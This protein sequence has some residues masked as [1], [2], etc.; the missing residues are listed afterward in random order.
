MKPLYLLPLLLLASC[1]KDDEI[2]APAPDDTPD[3]PTVIVYDYTPAPG[4]FIGEQPMAGFTGGE[5]TPAAAIA[6][7]EGRLEKGLFVS[8][9]G[10]G[11][12]IVMGLG[13]PIANSHGGYDFA[14]RGNAFLSDNGGG[15][16][17]P[18]IV[19]VMR[20]DNGNGLPDD[21]WHE[22]R[23]SDQGTADYAVTYYRPEADG[24]P[25]R[26]TDNQGGS[27]TIDY[28]ASI[29]SQ[30]SYYPAWIDA[31]SY[32]LAGTL[33]PS[34][35]HYDPATGY[36]GC[37]PYRWGY[38]DNVGDDWLEGGINRFRIADADVDL[39]HID[40]V[41]VQTAI[42]CKSGILG[43]QSTEVFSLERL[44]NTGK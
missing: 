27:G 17:E 13:Q 25:V 6:Y 39:D 10:F 18:G 42:N 14:I 30:K 41:R 4:Q 35:N 24:Q 3:A 5:T 28:L 11:G 7:A 29:H 22:L 32:T 8:L 38:A 19:S 34:R 37:D 44:D 21:T 36:W 26:W 43:E 40:F 16:S 33:L 12:Y 1:N 31:D 15:M 9:G 23:G 20:D 2:A